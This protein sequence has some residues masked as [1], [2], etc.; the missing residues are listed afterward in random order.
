MY[1]EQPFVD[2]GLAARAARFAALGDATRLAVV[3]AL[4]LCDR[5]P[6]EL[7]AVLAVPGNLLAHHLAVLERA[8]LIARRPSDADGRRKY[9]QLGAAA[10]DC[11]S[12]FGAPVA[13]DRVRASRLLFVCRRNSAR[14]QLAAALWNARSDVPAHSAGPE[15]AR[16]VHPRAVR[17]AR[18]HGLDLGGR[19]PRGYGD[20]TEPPDLVVSVCDSAR[21]GEMPFGEAALLHWSIPDPVRAPEADAFQRAFARLSERVARLA[22]LVRRAA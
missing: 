3:E 10:P 6:A 14:S 5:T 1:V 17:V 12:A 4:A 16:R 11:L 18:D 20:V 21:E 22:P 2:E 7:A 8:G 13:V 19:R 9:V 15:P